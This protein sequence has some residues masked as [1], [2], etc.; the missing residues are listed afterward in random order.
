MDTVSTSAGTIAAPSTND[1]G[2]A[3][4]HRPDPIAPKAVG[5]QA[6]AEQD[7]PH[8]LRTRPDPPAQ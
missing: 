8:A 3:P 4:G 6:G 1:K 2:A 5:P 7:L